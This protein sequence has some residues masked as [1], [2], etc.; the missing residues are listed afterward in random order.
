[1]TAAAECWDGMGRGRLRSTGQRREIVQMNA[2]SISV[3]LS[4]INCTKRAPSPQ[5]TAQSPPQPDQSLR[6]TL[7]KSEQD[8]PERGR[9]VRLASAEQGQ[10]HAGRQ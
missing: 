8:A 3:S 6:W 7:A 5:V 9:R 1:M 10:P 2:N 4:V